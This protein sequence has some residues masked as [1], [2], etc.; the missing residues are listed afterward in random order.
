M[1]G[2]ACEMTATGVTAIV[3]FTN[4]IAIDDDV[5]SR[6]ESLLALL[7]GCFLIGC[8]DGKQML[9]TGRGFEARIDAGGRRNK[10]QSRHM[11]MYVDGVNHRPWT[12]LCRTRHASY[13]LDNPA[14][15]GTT[16][17]DDCRQDED[18][19]APGGHGPRQGGNERPLPSQGPRAAAFWTPREARGV[20]EGGQGGTSLLPVGQGGVLLRWRRELC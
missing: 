11:H 3:D 9:T 14:P 1:R 8:G 7:A 5:M 15:N 2:L 16:C 10:Q 17:H 18:D 4:K 19:S 13:T 12:V 6:K 20:R